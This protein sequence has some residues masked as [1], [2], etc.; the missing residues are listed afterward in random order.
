MN[1]YNALTNTTQQAPRQPAIGYV[2]TDKKKVKV[3][4]IGFVKGSSVIEVNGV[5]LPKTKYDTSRKLADG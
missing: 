2:S 3:D 1:A 4:G 5:E